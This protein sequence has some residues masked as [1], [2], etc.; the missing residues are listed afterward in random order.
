MK[1]FADKDS[2]ISWIT[3]PEHLCG[4]NNIVHGGIIST[5]C[6]EVMSW[7]GIYFLKQITLTKSITIDFMKAIFVN[8]ELRVEGKI[9]DRNHKREAIIEGMIYNHE[10]QLCAKSIGTF[11]LLSPDVARRMRIMS[12]TNIKSFFEPLTQDL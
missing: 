7:T 3:V 9:V 1:F 5:I 10:E 11:A 6:D 8:N 2:I 12:D 4:W